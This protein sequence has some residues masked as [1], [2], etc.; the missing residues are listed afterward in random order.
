M[1]FTL[2]PSMYT[3][4][5]FTLYN[6]PYVYLYITGIYLIFEYNTSLVYEVYI[7]YV[8]KLYVCGYITTYSV[9]G[10]YMYQ[11]IDA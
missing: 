10:R 2:I 5:I 9:W 7:M 6:V 8:I 4:W 1:G 3:I 11:V